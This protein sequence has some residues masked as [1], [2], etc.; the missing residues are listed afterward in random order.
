MRVGGP[1]RLMVDG[2]FGTTANRLVV[3]DSGVH[4]AYW[5][6]PMAALA[7]RAELMF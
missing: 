2:L 5:G 3:R 4:V 7:L 1:F 6:Q